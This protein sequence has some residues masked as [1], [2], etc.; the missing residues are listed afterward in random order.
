MEIAIYAA[1]FIL[2]AGA[3]GFAFNPTEDQKRPLAPEPGV[4]GDAHDDHG[5]GGHH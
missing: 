5:H 3:F 2:L 4:G 1:L